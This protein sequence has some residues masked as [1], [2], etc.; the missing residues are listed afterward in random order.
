MKG[1]DVL[2]AD[3]GRPGSPQGTGRQPPRTVAAPPKRRGGGRGKAPNPLT[4]VLSAMF[5]LALAY[6]AATYSAT[7]FIP[8]LK[9]NFGKDNNVLKESVIPQT[10]TTKKAGSSSSTNDDGRNGEGEEGHKG[11]EI[12][13]EGYFTPLTDTSIFTQVALSGGGGST[14]GGG[15]EDSGTPF[16]FYQNMS[17]LGARCPGIDA[18]DINGDDRYTKCIPR[19]RKCT[20]AVL[21]LPLVVRYEGSHEQVGVPAG[22]SSA[23]SDESRVQFGYPPLAFP[24][25]SPEEIALLAQKSLTEGTSYDPDSIRDRILGIME[26]VLGTYGQGG[27]SGPVSL[28]EINRGVYSIGDKFA[29]LPLT[30]VKALKKDRDAQLPITVANLRFMWAIFKAV[31]QQVSEFLFCPAF[32]CNT[33][34]Q[35]MEAHKRGSRTLYLAS[36]SFFSKISAGKP[37]RNDNDEYWHLHIDRLQYGSFAV[38]TLLYLDTMSAVGSAMYSSPTHRNKAASAPRGDDEVSSGECTAGVDFSGGGFVFEGDVKAV[39]HPSVGRLSMFTSSAENPH[40]VD[41]VRCGVRRAL[42]IAF[43]CDSEVGIRVGSSYEESGLFKVV[44]Q[45]LEF[46]PDTQD[47]EL[48]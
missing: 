38:T 5:V 3:K 16:I 31:E 4:F 29:S 45:A 23:T 6:T 37:P 41:K 46:D 24:Q 12:S 1:K 2:A 25:P 44:H 15:A 8:W 26:N 17:A 28:V 9:V 35:R 43:T 34:R 39:V 10:D 36:P 20:R 40:Y 33:T 21:D 18:P 11:H 48:N 19:S 7:T 22:S 32:P 42:T 27:G 30:I 13:D 47:V 14:D